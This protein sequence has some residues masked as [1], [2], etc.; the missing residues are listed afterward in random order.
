[1]T[2]LKT[3]IAELSEL[4]AQ[5]LALRA[6]VKAQVDDLK[7]RLSPA[8]MLDQV[9][10]NAAEQVE[11]VAGPQ[12][13]QG[14]EATENIFADI[15]DLT[16]GLPQKFERNCDELIETARE[17]PVAAAAIAV[18]IGI[19]IS[20]LLGLNP[21]ASDDEEDADLSDFESTDDELA[22]ADD[23]SAFAFDEEL[24]DGH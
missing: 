21:F 10:D 11:R 4:N 9:L 6:T 1:M 13:D 22:E 16:D 7:Y 2:S 24:S 5:R 15:S 20:W 23:A 14:F 18:A 3:Q 17:H 19:L 8:G 12:I